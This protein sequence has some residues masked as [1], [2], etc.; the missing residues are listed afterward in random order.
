MDN[1][2]GNAIEFYSKALEFDPENT[3]VKQ[4]LMVALFTDGGGFRKAWHW[5]ASSRRI[6]RSRRSRAW[7]WHGGGDQQARVPQGRQLLSRETSNPIDRLLN[8]LLKAWADLAMAR[9]KRR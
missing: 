4:R 8:T 7:R 6:P 5:H 2:T 3:E 1:D 9:A